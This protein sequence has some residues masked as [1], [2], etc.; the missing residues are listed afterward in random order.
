M[1]AGF[2]A[3]GIVPAAMP[4]NGHVYIRGGAQAVRFAWNARMTTMQARNTIRCR[5][6]PD[7]L[8]SMEG[9]SCP[10]GD[11]AGLLRQ[12]KLASNCSNS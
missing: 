8:Q 4:G 12:A 2:V 3:S 6:P 11:L 5:R 10:L 1:G 9:A 7:H